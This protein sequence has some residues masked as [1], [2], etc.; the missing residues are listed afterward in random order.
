M[1]SVSTRLRVNEFLVLSPESREM[2]QDSHR[3]E[4]TGLHF[5]WGQGSSRDSLISHVFAL[6]WAWSLWETGKA[7]L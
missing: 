5:G 1:L 6:G 7:S 3:R 4:T 2:N